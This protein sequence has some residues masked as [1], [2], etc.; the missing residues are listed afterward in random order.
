MLDK[1]AGIFSGK[2]FTSDGL[3]EFNNENRMLR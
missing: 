2:R 3:L 1:M